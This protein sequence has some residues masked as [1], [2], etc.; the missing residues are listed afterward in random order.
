[1]RRRLLAVCL[2]VGA[3]WLPRAANEQVAP[4]PS[5]GIVINVP[6][7]RLDVVRMG[8]R[9]TSYRV[10][11]GMP[12]F[13]TPRGSF[14]ITSIEWNPAWI[15]PDRD[16]AKHEVPAPPGPA[17]P[18]G[19]AK[20]NFRPLYFL[21]GTPLT[22]TIGSAASHG[23]VRL[24]N[25]DAVALALEVTRAGVSGADSSLLAQLRTDTVS[26][27]VVVLDAPIAV[28]LRYDLAELLGGR[29]VLYP[30]VYRLGAVSYASVREVIERATIDTARI[31]SVR[32]VALMRRARTRVVSV[33]VDSV[34]KKK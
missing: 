26:T 29:L 14:S 28:E 16:W 4:P 25:V 23:C 6:A 32:V 1:M 13:R 30:D 5:L 24:S 33:S 34:L 2:V 22:T 10:A 7:Y 21:H 11:I 31:D 20:L 8:L 15:P 3:L 27:R 9:E 12:G 17:N 18:M 19:R